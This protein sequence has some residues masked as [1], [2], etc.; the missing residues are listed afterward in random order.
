MFESKTWIERIFW[1][2][3]VSISIGGFIATTTL[4][5]IKLA[6]E[7]TATSISLTREKELNFPAVTIC[8]LSLFNVTTISQG[9]GDGN[10]VIPRDLLNVIF[11]GSIPQCKRAANMLAN[12][13]QVNYSWGELL[14]VAKSDAD[15]LIVGCAYAGKE[16]SSSDFKPVTTAAGHCFTFNKP[17]SPHQPVLTANGTGVRR[18]LQLRLSPVDQ[19]SSILGDQGFR[20]V[21]HNPDELPRPE[22]EGIVVGL[23]SMVYIGMKQV[24]SHIK[25]KF[26]SGHQCRKEMNYDQDLSFPGYSSYSPSLCQTE[27]FLKHTADRCGCSEPFL[28]TPV[29]S[30]YKQLRKCTF[31]DMCCFIHAFEEARESCECLPKCES[32]EHTFTVSS[33]SVPKGEPVGVNVFYESLILETRM[34]T[35]SYTPWILISDIGGNT[36]LF[37]G[38]SL[39]SAVE[40]MLLGI[41]ACQRCCTDSC[42]QLQEDK[43]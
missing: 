26:S 34:T 32:V 16:C 19:L 33:S 28:Y 39:L 31:P 37:L 21:I 29:S 7:P 22:A 8:S 2:I 38:F 23:D 1:G 4:E 18:G 14:D 5:I 36:A 40:L 15:G 25:T 9:G 10:A 42:R 30:K 35:E 13:T 20:V 24:N 41:R 3:I 6:R 11:G 17:D 27:C 43:I 12:Y